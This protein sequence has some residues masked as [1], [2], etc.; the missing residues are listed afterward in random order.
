MI[1]VCYRVSFSKK[2]FYLILFIHSFVI[3]F[4]CLE[5]I[6]VIKSFAELYN[7]VDEAVLKQDIKGFLITQ[8]IYF[9]IKIIPMV[10]LGVY[11]YV[12]FL[13]K[14]INKLFVYLFFMCISIIFINSLLQGSVSLV[15]Y[16]PKLIGYLML[17]VILIKLFMSFN[18]KLQK[19]CKI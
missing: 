7:L 15:L 1:Y 9:F 3:F 2:C 4:E 12:S 14:Y 17:I 13:K 8:F 6:V 16:Y 5:S 18:K 10:I 11:T 19:E